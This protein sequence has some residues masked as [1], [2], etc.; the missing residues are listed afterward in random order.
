MKKEEKDRYIEYIKKLNDQYFLKEYR[1]VKS[2]SLSIDSKFMKKQCQKE[3]EK[4][5]IY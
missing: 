5:G 4:R 2:F 1:K 3:I